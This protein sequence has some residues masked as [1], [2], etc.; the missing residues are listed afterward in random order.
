MIRTVEPAR[1][2][3]PKRRRKDDHGKQEENPSNFKPN[4]AANPSKGLEEAAHAARKT[5]ACSFDTRSLLRRAMHRTRWCCGGRSLG[6]SVDS[7]ACDAAR[8]A[9]ADAQHPSNAFRSHFDMMVTACNW[10]SLFTGLRPR[11]LPPE[12]S[13]SKVEQS[14]AAP[15][16]R[17][18]RPTSWRNT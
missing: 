9:Q 6:C 3:T 1:A 10:S 2:C 14:H 18:R 16:P 17:P 11:W 4:D 12:H 5:A 13:R 7:L 8:N 15:A